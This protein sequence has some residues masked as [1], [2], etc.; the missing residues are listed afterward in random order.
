MNRKTLILIFVISAFGLRLQAQG[1]LYLSNLGESGTGFV[2]GSGSQSFV[3]GTASNGYALNYITLFMGNMLDNASNFN[4]L[5]Y[6]DNGGQVGIPLGTLNGN[7][8]PSTAGQYNYTASNLVLTSNTTY[9]IVTTCDSSSP[10]NP[11]PPG[12]YTWKFT[13][14]QN[15]SS[16]GNWSIGP[17]NVGFGGSVFQFAVNAT[18][19]P[20][21]SVCALFGFGLT[22]ILFR[23]RN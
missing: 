18:P 1:T 10:G 21:P 15:Y 6:N 7:N 22:T 12:G 11:L 17:G 5:V 23:R 19:A 3:T 16:S 2:V 14:S 20:E 8:N 13:L 9:W 4:V